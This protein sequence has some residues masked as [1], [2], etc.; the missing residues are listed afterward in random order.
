[1]NEETGL[2]SPSNETR[3]SQG[4]QDGFNIKR[5]VLRTSNTKKHPVSE[6]AHYSKKHSHSR[7]FDR[8]L[9]FKQASSSSRV[10]LV[11]AVKITDAPESPLHTTSSSFEVIRQTARSDAPRTPS[12][13]KSKPGITGN[14]GVP[15]KSRQIMCSELSTRKSLLLLRETKT[16]HVSLSPATVA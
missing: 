16:R 14:G 13:L 6:D 2:C 11:A 5:L 12:H 15:K 8:F 4:C 3:K 7:N 9:Y 10:K 1:M